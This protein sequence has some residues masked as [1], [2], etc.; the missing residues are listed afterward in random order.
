MYTLQ[1]HHCKDPLQHHPATHTWLSCMC[2]LY[3][4]VYIPTWINYYFWR[5]YSRDNN[6]F[7]ARE[8]STEIDSKS[9]DGVGLGEEE[10]RLEDEAEVL[11]DMYE[12]IQ[13]LY[14][15]YQCRHFLGR[16]AIKRTGWRRLIG[17]PKLHII[18][19]KRATKYRSL[20]QKM[21]HKDK[22]SY[23]SSPPCTDYTPTNKTRIICRSRAQRAAHE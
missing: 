6:T 10:G 5:R 22:G 3:R 9:V 7:S 20:L 17:S 11:V 2:T 21:T 8:D 19:H 12:I 4:H 14:V 16:R 23:E 13:K 15:Y 1:Q 18:F